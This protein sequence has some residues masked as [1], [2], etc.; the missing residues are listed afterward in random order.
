MSSQ[1]PPPI[2]WPGNRQGAAP[3]VQ[4]QGQASR[5]PPLP[6]PPGR[7]LAARPPVIGNPFGA[8]RAPVPSLASGMV[9][10]AAR[11]TPG[12]SD[13][14]R[15]ATSAP[16]L[17]ATQAYVENRRA[18]ISNGY[19]RGGTGIRAGLRHAQLTHLIG[20][21]TESAAVRQT[22]IDLN[23][24]LGR[25]DPG[26]HP[27]RVRTENM[28]LRLANTER[29]RLVHFPTGPWQPIPGRPDWQQRT[30]ARH[31]RDPIVMEQRL[32]A[33]VGG[34]GAVDDRPFQPP[35]RRGRRR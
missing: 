23:R 27:G 20:A 19:T 18:T 1:R 5:C 32:L 34:G 3:A 22:V 2:S 10:R 4:K 15:G 30:A 7:A 17:A 6:A 29:N 31:D 35:S 25:P 16:E 21:L 33:P 8:A 11:T 14:E 12:L 13:R 26:N 9:Q 24:Q 28:M